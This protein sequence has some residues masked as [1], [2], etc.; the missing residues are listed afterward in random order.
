M[1]S[2]VLH[3]L[4]MPEI[5][6]P[7]IEEW[8]PPDSNIAYNVVGSRDLYRIELGVRNSDGFSMRGKSPWEKLKPGHTLEDVAKD[9]MTAMGDKAPIFDVFVEGKLYQVAASRPTN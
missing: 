2:I 3:Y 8:H 7:I 9:E 1:D 6:T 5:G 4:D